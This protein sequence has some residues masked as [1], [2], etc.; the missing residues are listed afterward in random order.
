MGAIKSFL[1]KDLKI[2]FRTPLL[3]VILLLYP[4]VVML[5][6]A[7]LTIEVSPAKIGIVNMDI[8]G[9]GSFS[10]EFIN[11]GDGSYDSEGL[12]GLMQD[13]NIKYARYKDKE[14]GFEALRSQ[15]IDILVVIPQDFVHTL[16]DVDQYASLELILNTV[17]LPKAAA[18]RDSFVH[19][20]MDVN[21]EIIQRKANDLT[22]MLVSIAEGGTIGG[23]EIRGLEKASADLERVM[24]LLDPES[25]EYALLLED[26]ELTRKIVEELDKAKEIIIST[27]N[28]VQFEEKGLT[29]KPIDFHNETVA[30]ALAVSIIITGIICGSS[31]L[32]IERENEVY[33]R[34]SAVPISSLGILISKTVLS[35]G[36]VML[37]SL[38][39]LFLSLIFI[40][41]APATVLVMVLVIV[42]AALLSVSFGYLLAGFT[43]SVSQAA[44]VAIYVAFPIIILSGAIIPQSI[45]SGGIEFVSRL[46]PFSYIVET[47]RNAFGGNLNASMLVT[48]LAIIMASFVFFMVIVLISPTFRGKR[49][50]T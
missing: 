34:F 28:P 24:G 8:Y 45:M 1:A 50:G 43:K 19:A 25:E 41:I 9:K 36:I 27:I 31:L 22:D 7:F 38:A 6:I 49:C 44:L 14:S 26:Y 40:D 15:D 18:S 4:F 3:F 13:D 39:I 32:A 12:I 11:I 20:F 42:A 47:T 33:R 37:Q 29:E 21:K 23:E 30:I 5:T 48:N 10:G 2:I 35:A 46:V 17:V 16:R